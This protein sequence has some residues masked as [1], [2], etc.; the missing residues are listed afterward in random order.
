[1]ADLFLFYFLLLT[2][3]IAAAILGRSK[4]IF[5]GLTD[6]LINFADP[7]LF[8]ICYM[9]TDSLIPTLARDTVD[10]CIRPERFEEYKKHRGE[11]FEDPDSELHQGGKFKCEGEFLRA[12]FPGTKMYYLDNEINELSDGDYTP[13]KD[14]AGSVYRA[15]GISHHGQSNLSVNH[16]KADVDSS[17]VHTNTWKL[18]GFGNMT[19]GMAPVSRKLG[20]PI[21]LKRVFVG[22]SSSS[23]GACPLMRVL[24]LI[25][26]ILLYLTVQRS[27]ERPSG[28]EQ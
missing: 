2:H 4:V 12:F 25:F 16:F 21:N 18:R 5:M 1:M 8:Q 22:V 15:K 24:C 20:K 23:S 27:A 3:Q 17:H 13:V 14:I 7:S 11:I 19:V 10:A 26:I 28:S 9:D 6:H